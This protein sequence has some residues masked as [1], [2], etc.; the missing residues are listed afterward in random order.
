MDC[1]IC[2][3]KLR[4]P[5][6]LSCGHTYCKPCIATWFHVGRGCNKHCPVCK[7]RIRE[8]LPK[9]YVE[10]SIAPFPGRSLSFVAQRPS[11]GSPTSSTTTSLTLSPL[12]GSRSETRL[13]MRFVP[14]RGNIEVRESG[15]RFVSGFCIPVKIIAGYWTGY[16]VL[17]VILRLHMRGISGHI[18]FF[19]LGGVLYVLCGV[20][21]DT[22]RDG[23]MCIVR[24][25]SDQDL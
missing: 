24:V 20:C 8:R 1:T 19:M 3:G 9:M 17:N 12:P 13:S 10:L 7:A 11:A 4:D 21:H 25:S 16:M 14:G 15:N 18:F 2:A 23:D 6:Q 22:W 5:F